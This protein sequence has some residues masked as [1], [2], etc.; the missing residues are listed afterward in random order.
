MLNHEE[1]N[2]S[3]GKILVRVN[4]WIGD[5]VMISPAM[6]A[7]RKAFPR[8]EISLLAKT[9]VLE[10][11][12][13]SPYYDHLIEYDRDGDHASWVGR[14]KLIERLR[15][16]RFDLALL[17]QKAFEAA[18]FA[19]I[20]CIPRR[21]G[22]Q[23]D[24]RGWLLTDPLPLPMGGH[25]VDHFLK[26]VEALGA[27]TTDRRLSYHL[28]PQARDAAIRFLR[29]HG[30]LQGRLRIA[31]HPG[32]SKPPRAWHAERFGE[33][34]AALAQGFGAIPIF[35]G[36]GHDLQAIERI[37]SLVGG[38]CVFPPEG[39]SLQE[40]AALLEHCHLLVCNDSGPMH[41][42]AAL[43]VPVVSIFGPGTPSR[44]GPYAEEG[45]FRAVTRQFPCSPCRQKFFEECLPAASGK[46]TC[47][48]EITSAEVLGA[49]RDLL[50]INAMGGATSVEGHWRD[51]SEPAPEP[52]V[53]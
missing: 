53:R 40:M 39:Q 32:A 19:R 37:R 8:A 27:D 12:Q 22:F 1:L 33:V 47:L 34:A 3:V 5:V 10:A 16:E 51:G 36:T 28:T 46:P 2:G 41:I 31:L 25:H 52:S 38:T 48:E 30:I 20:A 45:L 9:W 23:S 43:R 11:L 44:T 24:W 15:K 4:N 7:V 14:W 50:G 17:F 21:V 6:R 26:I 35:F 13:G 18:V 49:C 29:R 42:A